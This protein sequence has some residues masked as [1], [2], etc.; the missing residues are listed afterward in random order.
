M[1]AQMREIK[2]D[3]DEARK[4]L[5]AA[6]QKRDVE[7]AKT[8]KG[9]LENLNELYNSAETAFIAELDEPADPPG[10][11]E[12]NKNEE[13]PKYDAKLFYKAIS[14][15]VN[16]TDAEREV[17][18]GSRREYSNRYSE[19]EK[20]SG[21]YTVPVDLS[22]EILEKLKND[23]SVRNI[24]HV[25]NVNYPTGIRVCKSGDADRLY[26]T[27]EYEEIKE[28]NN[29]N[30][31]P[32]TYNQK[33]FA[34]LM[35]LSNEL[36]NDS[37]VN[38][39][40]EITDWLSRCARTTENRQILYGVGGEKHCQGILSTAGAYSEVTAPSS[41][42]IEFLRKVKFALQSGYRT[43][44]KWLMNTDVF[45]VI[46]EIKEDNRSIIQPDPLHEEQYMLLGRPIVIFDEIKT[47]DGK[48]PLLF[49]DFDKAYRMFVR[50][51]FGIAFTDV[52]AGAFE[53]DSVKARGIERFDGKIVDKNA[54]V[55]V[56]DIS[57]EALSV[58]KPTNDFG[59]SDEITKESLA[60]LS[61][62]QLLEIV[63]DYGIT[64]LASNAA[65]ATIIDAII[66]AVTEEPPAES[67]GTE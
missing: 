12:G 51:D 23:E 2:A 60:Y 55:I 44:S 58:T 24:V 42:T 27:G 66:A 13:K 15:S 30:Y 54:L 59:A 41:I 20:E 3:I 47:E 25:E 43:N 11:G 37:F 52:G 32:I 9:E 1:N 7:E 6:V 10:T 21:G 19:S 34:G 17:V 36:L 18:A 63:E 28:M 5:M 49:G 62:A 38:F 16:L 31:A 26:N 61:K 4:R 33:K 56:R 8:V 40:S 48:A 39:T 22:T 46:S 29:A 65:K 53:S 50:K 57:V 14:N 64:G 67:G 45:L 35:P